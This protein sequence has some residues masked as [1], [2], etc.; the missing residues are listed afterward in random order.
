MEA[1]SNKI[2][3]RIHAAPVLKALEKKN[4]GKMQ[5][6]MHQYLGHK[7]RGDG[8]TEKMLTG[9]ITEVYERLLAEMLHGGT[10]SFET[11]KKE[12]EELIAFN[13][14]VEGGLIVDMMVDL[15][16]QFGDRIEFR[17]GLPYAKLEPT[18]G[19]I[20]ASAAK[21]V[22][23]MARNALLELE[24]EGKWVRNPELK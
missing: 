16:K 22:S 12:L 24:K 20:V 6:K 2:E 4:L 21:V 7:F 5:R 23:K 13:K 9:R 15:N 17:D 3:V 18:Q 11:T 8:K 10:L 14:S 19:S 1:T